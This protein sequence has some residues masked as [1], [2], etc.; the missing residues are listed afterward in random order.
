MN[1]ACLLFPFPPTTN[2]LFAGRARRFASKGYRAWQAEADHALSLQAPLPRFDGPVSVV[3]TL[4]RPDKRRRDLANYEKAVIDRIVHH[5][6]LS[7]DSL[8]HELTMLWG[9]VTGCRVEI[10]PLTELQART[11]AARSIA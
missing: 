7:D 1:Y 8:I 2:N 10:E 9:D 11:Q 3:L 4:G 6:I 5:G